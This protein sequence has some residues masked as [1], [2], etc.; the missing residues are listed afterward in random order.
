MLQKL[1]DL[2]TKPRGTVTTKD[3]RSGMYVNEVPTAKLWELPFFL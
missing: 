3:C 2:L 1:S